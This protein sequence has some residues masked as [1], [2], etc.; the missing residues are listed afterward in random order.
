MSEPLKLFSLLRRAG[1]NVTQAEALCLFAG[2]A[3]TPSEVA[4]ITG[5]SSA[6]ATHTTRRLEKAGLI[7][8]EEC[9]KDNRKVRIVLTHT[10]RSFVLLM[11]KPELDL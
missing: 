4:R 8:R 2:G 11:E 9:G 6:L 10:G 1:L 5:T 7:R 3:S